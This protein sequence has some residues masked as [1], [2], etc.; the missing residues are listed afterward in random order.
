M[1]YKVTFTQNYTYEVDASNEDEALNKAYK[2]FVREMCYSLPNTLY[3]YWDIEC[4]DEED[5]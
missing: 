2:D 1:N 3:D 5:D 4:E